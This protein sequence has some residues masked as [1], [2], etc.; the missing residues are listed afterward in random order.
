MSTA[1]QRNIL[2]F[3]RYL[4]KS[5]FSHERLLQLRQKST[6]KA[7]VLK[8]YGSPLEISDLKV[9]KLKKNEVNF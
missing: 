6:F 3:A 4:P 9:T 7:A 2:S 1:I 5:C 8:E